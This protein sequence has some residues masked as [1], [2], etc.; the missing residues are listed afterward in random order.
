MVVSGL[1]DVF[2]STC[3]YTQCTK[4]VKMYCCGY[5]QIRRILPKCKWRSRHSAVKMF[6]SGCLKYFKNVA[7]FNKYQQRCELKKLYI[8]GKDLEQIHSH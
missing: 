6:S 3:I 5:S 1:T 4:I 7:V 8:Y 2:V